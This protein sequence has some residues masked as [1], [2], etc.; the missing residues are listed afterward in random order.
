MLHGMLAV[1]QDAASQTVIRHY[2]LLMW[3]KGENIISTMEA[4][5]VTFRGLKKSENATDHLT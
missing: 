4:T 1:I 2:G 5:P 3:Y